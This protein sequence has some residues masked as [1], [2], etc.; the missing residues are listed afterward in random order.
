MVE[1][2]DEDTVVQVGGAAAGPL[3]LVV[4]VAVGGWAVQPGAAAPR[5]RAMTARRW[6]EDEA[7]AGAAEVEHLATCPSRRSA[8]CL[9]HRRAGELRRP[10]TCRLV[11]QTGAGDSVA[12]RFEAGGDATLTLT[13]V[14]AGRRCAGL[15]V[16]EG[17]AQRPD[18]PVAAALL[19]RAVVLE[20]VG[21]GVRHVGASSQ[22]VTTG[23][24]AGRMVN[25]SPLKP[26]R[27]VPSHDEEGRCLGLLGGPLGGTLFALDCSA[28]AGSSTD[29]R[30]G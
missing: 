6:A 14:A 22:P 3:A 5:S 10:T 30:V 28:S 29:G 11:E 8:R 4:D 12:E 23:T 21:A 26:C 15:R 25:R 20:A 24:S 13:F 27:R 9:H 16:R 19:A 7:P 17:V 2:A 18:E 1:L